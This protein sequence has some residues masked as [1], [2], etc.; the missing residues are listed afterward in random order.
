[1]LNIGVALL[2]R[3]E[4]VFTLLLQCHCLINYIHNDS[5]Y[6]PSQLGSQSGQLFGLYIG[7]VLGGADIP[8]MRLNLKPI[9]FTLSQMGIHKT[10]YLSYF[11]SI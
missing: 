7:A 5:D 10:F 4:A 11:F 2:P 9:C 6:R 3:Y 1:M 8:P